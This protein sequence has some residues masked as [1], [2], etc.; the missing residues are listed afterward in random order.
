MKLLVAV[1]AL[2]TLSGCAS[3]NTHLRTGCVLECAKWEN[4]TTTASTGP[5]SYT[6]S[7]GIS[8]TQVYLPNAGYSVIQSGSTIS[9]I[10]TSRSR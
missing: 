7:T 6:P 1:L 10:Q 9:V 2:I 5:S 4:V 3:Y 8:S